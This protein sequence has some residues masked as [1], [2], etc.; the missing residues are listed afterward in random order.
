MKLNEMEARLPAWYF[1]SVANGGAAP[2]VTGR[3]GVGKTD[4]LELF[5]TVMKRIDPAHEYGMITQNG[6]CMTLSTV[7]GYLWPHEMTRTDGSKFAYSRFTKPD[8]WFDKNGRAMDTFYGGVLLVDEA[9]KLGVD[10]KKIVG[11]AALS[12]RLASHQFPDRWVIWFAGNRAEDRSGS[13]K[14]LDHLILRRREIPVREDFEAWKDW[15]MN[16]G[17]VLPEVISCMEDNPQLLFESKPEV[18]RPYGSPRT[19]NQASIHLRA[20]MAAFGTDKIPLDPL[21]QEELAGGVGGPTAAAI[22]VHIRLG[23]ELPSYKDIVKSPTTVPVPTKPDGKRLLAYKLAEQVQVPDAKAVLEYMT[24]LEQEFQV[25]FVRMAAAR[26]YQL[27][28]EKEMAAWCAKHTA[29]IA[30]LN[31]YKDVK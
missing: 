4:T 10:E 16:R 28:F 5:P 11:E 25:V 27:V 26:N 15:A 3:P 29:L 2:Y 8:W 19:I 7:C 18:Q 12:K 24:R 31:R 30:I 21:T 13:T 1:A 20:L 14:E 22:M 23:Q 17:N 9:D 6:A